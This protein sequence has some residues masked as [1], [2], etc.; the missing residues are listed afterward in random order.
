MKK[1]TLILINC[2]FSSVGFCDLLLFNE[3][4]ESNLNN[5]TGKNY[6]AHHGVLVSDPLRT[7]NKVLSFNALDNGGDIFH[8]NGLLLTVGKTYRISF[9]YLGLAKTGSISDNYGGFFG[10]SDIVGDSMRGNHWLFGTKSNYTGL[11][12][13][14]ID[15]GQWSSYSYTFEWQRQEIEALD[16]RVHLMM[17]DWISSRGVAGDVYFDNISFVL[18][19][20]PAT[21]ILFGLGTLILSRKK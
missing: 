10:L 20:E 15:N 16:D 8:T 2:F 18:V 5:W 9:E 1:I 6:G 7:G 12:G 11:R 21:L 3:N 19:P 4:F 14:L 13:H 17:E